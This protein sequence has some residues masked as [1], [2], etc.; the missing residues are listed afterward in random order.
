[1]IYPLT[2]ILSLPPFVAHAYYHY[3]CK[4]KNERQDIKEV[5]R[6]SGTGKPIWPAR[7]MGAVLLMN[8]GMDDICFV[9]YGDGGGAKARCMQFMSITRIWCDGVNFFAGLLF[10]P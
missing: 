4:G 6:F 8:G 5:H 9:K 7:T 1:M 10:N 3:Y 2:L